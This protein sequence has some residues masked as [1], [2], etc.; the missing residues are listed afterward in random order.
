MSENETPEAPWT[1]EYMND[2]DGHDENFREWWIVS[3]G[4]RT[5]SSE[6]R[7]D[8][9]WLCGMLNDYGPFEEDIAPFCPG[10]AR[11]VEPFLKATHDEVERQLAEQT[12]DNRRDFLGNSFGEFCE[13]NILPSPIIGDE[14]KVSYRGCCPDPTISHHL[15][16]W[17]SW[18]HCPWCG[19]KLKVNK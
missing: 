4:Q 8:A 1:I 18:R 19:R 17:D 13:W 16:P 9:L 7:E 12:K 3:N 5:F 11:L 2:V 6:S 10:A 15:T 14:S